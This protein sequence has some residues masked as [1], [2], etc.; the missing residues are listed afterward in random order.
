M[1]E[2]LNS[3]I[4]RLLLLIPGSILGFCLSTFFYGRATGQ[5]GILPNIRFQVANYYISPHHW[6]Y[7]LMLVFILAFV[8]HKFNLL[9]EE[10]FYLLLGFG[11]GGFVQGLSYKDWFVIIT[12]P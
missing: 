2:L 5:E 6:M 3:A 10:V 9:S 1:H 8:H 12:R 7:F 11:I 4:A